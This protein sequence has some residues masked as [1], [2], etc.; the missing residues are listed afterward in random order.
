MIKN[1]DIAAERYKGIGLFERYTKR[2]RV[3]IFHAVY[4]GLLRG[5]NEIE[6]QDIVLGLAREP[7]QQGSPFAMLHTNAA[8]LRS[9]IGSKPEFHG[10]PERREIPLSDHSKRA[11][12]YADMEARHDRGY[13]IRGDHLLRGV[14][15]TQNGTAKKLAAAGYTLTEMRRVSIESN[16]L[17][18]DP[19]VPLAWRLRRYRRRLLWGVAAMMLVGAIL[20]LRSQN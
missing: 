1:S 11:L 4:E 8:E 18:P 13:W 6:P 9:L 2:S 12:A 3:A 16:R 17:F 15:R 5:S 7:H 10:P 14:L 19:K 20:Y